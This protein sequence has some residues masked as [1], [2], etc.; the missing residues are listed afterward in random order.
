MNQAG[1]LNMK[2]VMTNAAQYARQVAYVFL[3]YIKRHYIALFF[4][5]LVSLFWVIVSWNKGIEHYVSDIL[6]YFL[7]TIKESKPELFLRDFVFGDKSNYFYPP[8]YINHLKFFYE[9]TGDI[10]FGIKILIFPLNFIFML[11]AYHLFTYIKTNRWLSTLLAVFSS[12]PIYTATA[13]EIFGIGPATIFMVRTF[14]TAFVPIIIYLY[15]RGIIEAKNSILYLVFL[16]LGGLANIYPTTPLILAQILL[17]ATLFY[18]GFKKDTL[19]LAGKCGFFTL[20]AAIPSLLSHLKK[21]VSYDF[22]IPIEK[23]VELF[24]TSPSHLYPQ[25]ALLRLMPENILHL[26]TALLFVVPPILI[27][28]YKKTKKEIWGSLLFVFCFLDVG[29]VLYSSSNKYYLLFI[30]VALLVSWGKKI[31]KKDELSVYFGFSIFYLGIGSLII[32]SFLLSSDTI[33]QFLHN[34]FGFNP[35]LAAYQQRAIR[36]AGFELFVLCAICAQWIMSDYKRISAAKKLILSLLVVF[37]LFSSLKHVYKTYVRIKPDIARNDM[38][39]L[40]LW[41]KNNTPVN[42]LFLFDQYAFRVISERSVVMT[43]KDFYLF[44]FSKEKLMEAHNRL[45]EIKQNEKN[46]EGLLNI[47]RKYGADFII[48][49]NRDFP[50]LDKRAVVYQTGTYSVIASNMQF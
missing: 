28:F 8:S 16:M 23:V 31:D 49:K 40:S 17:F 26:V 3:E 48:L 22:N 43:P 15:Y 14:S 24:K 29:Y 32:N 33:V 35:L 27:Y 39:S 30:A 47:A 9:E 50:Y 44:F 21:S 7:L 6:Y 38:V 42:S 1:G 45:M 5:T 37:V 10:A 36:F 2:N 13:F 20:L 11:G 46:I 19:L 34:I 41:A 25:P 12:F 4:F 18:K